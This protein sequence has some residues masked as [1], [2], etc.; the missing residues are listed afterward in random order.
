MTTNNER[1][2][3]LDRAARYLTVAGLLSIS[4]DD[5]Y[6][7]ADLAI[8]FDTADDVIDVLGDNRPAPALPVHAIDALLAYAQAS[9]TSDDDYD[10]FRHE[11]RV[12]IPGHADEDDANW[13]E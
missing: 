4:A 13:D 6:T 9:Y 7:I 2:N 5:A 8:D 1:A 11:L 12:L 10:D 3:N